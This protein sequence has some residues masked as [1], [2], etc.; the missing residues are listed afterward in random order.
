MFAVLCSIFELN[1]PIHKGCE[2]KLVCV[3]L[4][5]CMYVLTEGE[6]VEEERE[7]NLGDLM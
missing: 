7:F 1:P 2:A 6:P 3:C 5:V 4:C